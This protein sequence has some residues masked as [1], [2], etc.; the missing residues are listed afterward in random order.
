MLK[1]AFLATSLSLVYDWKLADDHRPHLQ[2]S[3]LDN[4]SGWL[5]MAAGMA[6]LNEWPEMLLTFDPK[7]GCRRFLKVLLNTLEERK[8]VAEKENTRR[9]CNTAEGFASWRLFRQ[10]NGQVLLS[11]IL[12]MSTNWPALAFEDFGNFN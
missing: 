4:R 1:I 2:T 3:S 11:P 10:E 7:C 6:A 12:K 8:L 5:A 9:F